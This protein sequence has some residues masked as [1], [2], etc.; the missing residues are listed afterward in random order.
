MGL[1]H[2]TSGCSGSWNVG[3]LVLVCTYVGMINYYVGMLGCWSLCSY[4]VG[5]A[6]FMSVCW[7]SKYL[8][9]DSPMSRSRVL[10]I[11]VL[12]CGMSAFDLSF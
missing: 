2:H 4:G 12:S 10:C 1:V 3:M 11:V 7:D 8:W 5:V 6:V 9:Y